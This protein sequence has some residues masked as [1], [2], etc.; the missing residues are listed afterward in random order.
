M[1]K[2]IKEKLQECETEKEEYLNGWKRA[3]ADLINYKRDE[4]NRIES[5]LKERKRGI[6]LKIISVV[7]SFDRAIEMNEEDAFSEGFLKIKEQ[8]DDLL[9]KEGVESIEC[10]GEEFDPSFH[11]VIET[12][13][14][15]G[16]EN[17]VIIEEAQKGYKMDGE[18]LRPSRVKVAL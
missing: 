13:E 11:E 18:L 17:G 15:E 5:L 7:D 8:M 1:K 10:V 12:V 3:K 6:M 16:V 9:K 2:S 4:A 14:R